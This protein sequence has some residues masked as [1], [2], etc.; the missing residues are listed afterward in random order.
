MI[1]TSNSLFLLN[2]PDI[3]TG[4]ATRTAQKI[5][6]FRDRRAGWHYGSG[7]PISEGVV[8]LTLRLNAFLNYLSVLETDVFPGIDGE[9][10][11][12]CYLKEH[13]IEILIDTAKVVSIIHEKD[14]KIL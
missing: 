9:V 13:Y 3:N 12:T 14:N 2:A 10:L 1:P 5:L 6:S 11:L 4:L 7:G 8:R